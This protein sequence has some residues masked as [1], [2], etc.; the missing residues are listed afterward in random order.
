MM[1]EYIEALSLEL[2]RRNI[3]EKDDIIQYFQE[4]ITDRLEAGESIED[5]LHSLGE[6]SDVVNS[7]FGKQ[8]TPETEHEKENKGYRRYVEFVDISDVKVEN[9]SYDIC[10]HTSESEKTVIEY[11]DDE[12]STLKIDCEHHRL[13]IEQEYSIKGLSSLFSSLSRIF[14]KNA[15]NSNHKYCADIYL[16]KNADLDMKIDNTSGELRFD[17]I[18]IGKLK[19]DTVSGDVEMD[20][21][22]FEDVDSDFVSG[23][24]KICDVTIEDSLSADTVSGDLSIDMLRCEKIDIDSVSGDIDLLIDGERKDYDIRISKLMKDISYTGERNS[25]LKVDT[26]SGDIRF[27]FTR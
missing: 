2:Q 18:E 3:S 25:S 11:D 4:M 19:L 9:I 8:E 5:I 20:H 23:D 26:V 10:F 7:L 17:S 16:P 13:K 6:P 22:V 12:Y 24:L 14:S 21:C 27:D 1:N 15:Q